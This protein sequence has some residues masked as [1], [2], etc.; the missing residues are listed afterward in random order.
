MPVIET[1]KKKLGVQSD[2]SVKVEKVMKIVQKN[3][4]YTNDL[5]SFTV[6]NLNY[7]HIFELNLFFRTKKAICI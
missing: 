3:G 5:S 6:N 4:R 2:S 7:I 1:I